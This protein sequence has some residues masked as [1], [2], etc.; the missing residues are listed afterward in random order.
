M[1]FGD[2]TDLDVACNMAFPPIPPPLPPSQV[3]AVKY[4]SPR[5]VLYHLQDRIFLRPVAEL[6]VKICWSPS[7]CSGGAKHSPEMCVAADVL[8]ALLADAIAETVYLASICE[9]Q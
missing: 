1:K 2:E 7:A 5:V 3:P 9:L 8:A 4:H 6:R